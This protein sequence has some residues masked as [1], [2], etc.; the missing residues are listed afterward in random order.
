MTHIKK[1]LLSQEKRLGAAF[2]T[3]RLQVVPWAKTLADPDAFRGLQT[4]LTAM[5]TKPVLQHLPEQLQLSDAPDAIETWIAD[6]DQSAAIHLVSASNVLVGLMFLFRPVQTAATDP[7]HL[8]YLLGE[9]AWGKGYATELVSGLVA[10][11]STG[12]LMTLQ[13]GVAAGNPASAKVLLKAGFERSPQKSTDEI[14]IFQ[15]VVG[16]PDPASV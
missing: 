16:V 10:A 7:M 2:S 13:G 8:G 3:D 5:L 4:A 15:R 6:R 11:L 12:P 9:E 1:P 14:E